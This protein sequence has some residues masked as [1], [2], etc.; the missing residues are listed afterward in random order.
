MPSSSDTADMSS[1]MLTSNC[2][3]AQSEGALVALI[4]E[5]LQAPLEQPRAASSGTPNGILSA[6]TVQTAHTG[7]A[8]GCHSG[9]GFRLGRPRTRPGPTP[10]LELKCEEVTDD[11]VER[12]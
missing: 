2:T 12:S 1:T 9:L 3:P 4:E 5:H 6:E 8:C 7:C 11:T 10:R